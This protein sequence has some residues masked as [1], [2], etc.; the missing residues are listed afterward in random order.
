M[1]H[2]PHLYFPGNNSSKKASSCYAWQRKNKGR[3][4]RQRNGVCEC[5]AGDCTL[6]EEINPSTTM[7]E[8]LRPM[9]R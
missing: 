8:Q 9:L 3:T 2:A 6:T 5:G 4:H 7:Q 1:N